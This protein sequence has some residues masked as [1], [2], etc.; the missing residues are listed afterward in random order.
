LNAERLL[1]GLPLCS[2]ST[3]VVYTKSGVMIA[4]DADGLFRLE[5]RDAQ[6][7]LRG[8]SRSLVEESWALYC[9]GVSQSIFVR[10]GK[11]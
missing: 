1:L 4:M 11:P 10:W 2:N 9:A 6:Y 7:L 3:N 8:P 5:W